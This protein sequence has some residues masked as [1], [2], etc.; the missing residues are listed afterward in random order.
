LLWEVFFP[1]GREEEEAEEGTCLLLLDDV[2]LEVA[3]EE[4]GVDERQESLSIS[5]TTRLLSDQVEPHDITVVG[6]SEGFA[7]P[8]QLHLQ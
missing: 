8:S 1:N 7:I 4:R 3:S 6:L 2:A 5:L